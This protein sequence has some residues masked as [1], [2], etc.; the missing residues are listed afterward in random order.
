LGSLPSGDSAAQ[1]PSR[2]I[3]FDR[4]E[5]NSILSAYGRGVA[6]G[7]WKDY[8]MDALSDRALFSIYKRASEAPLYQIEKRPELARKQGAWALLSA[9]GMI[10]KRGH[11]LE[12]LLR[13]FDRK[14][15]AL[16]GD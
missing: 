14:R 11:D 2:R 8:A 10:L 16:V 3:F 5:L 4:R 1:P 12:S 9:Q 15:F 7:D 6:Q 13:F